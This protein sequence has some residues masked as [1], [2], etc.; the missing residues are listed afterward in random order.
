MSSSPSGIAAPTESRIFPKT[1]C[2]DALFFTMSR[3]L[4]EPP[5]QEEDDAAG[6]PAPPLPV[7]VQAEALGVEAERPLEGARAQQQ[8]AREH[9]HRNPSLP[10]PTSLPSDADACCEY[11]ASA[12]VLTRLCLDPMPG[13][14][15]HSR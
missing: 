2:A 4:E 3:D 13:S 7:D 9:L 1:S 5:A 12:S 6:A 15:P 10:G 11:P 8:A 14:V